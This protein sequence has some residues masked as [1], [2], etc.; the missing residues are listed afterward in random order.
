[1]TAD[2]EVLGKA[3]GA[4]P[5]TGTCGVGPGGAALA[6]KPAMHK[7]KGANDKTEGFEG[8]CRLVFMIFV[9]LLR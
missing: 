4:P 8:C 9:G 5:P 6:L 7:A 2:T 3:P 1:M